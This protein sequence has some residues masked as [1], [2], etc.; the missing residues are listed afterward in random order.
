MLNWF[1]KKSPTPTNY[2]FLAADMHAHLLPGIDDGAPNLETS[3]DM[4]RKMAEMGYQRVVA[5]PHVYKEFY[6]N[7]S[8]VIQT[9][10][11]ELRRA[12]QQAQIPLQIDAAAEYFLDS[13]FETLLAND[14]ILALP[15][16]FVLVE[17]SF[18]DSYPSF[19]QVI[20]DLQL[21]GYRP[22]LAHPE[23]YAYLC[24]DTRELSR[25]VD[26]GCRLQV[27]LLSLGGHYGPMA[28][29]AAEKMIKKG[30]VS[31]LGTDAHNLKHLAELSSI[32]KSSSVRSLL[33]GVELENNKV[34][35]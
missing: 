21:K 9:K 11:A 30:L 4:L 15:G 34:Q 23:R 3:L 29:N 14:D 10:L 32:M 24:N 12:A 33:G 28:R 6:P 18:I 8:E 13:H 20:F 31:M 22:I 7:T 35:G 25:I 27:N 1:N 26:A 2:S 5:T 16:N 17:M 19:R